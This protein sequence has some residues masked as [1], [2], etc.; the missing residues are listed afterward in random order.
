[1]EQGKQI[2]FLSDSGLV[3]VNGGLDLLINYL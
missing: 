1:M 3:R 2:T